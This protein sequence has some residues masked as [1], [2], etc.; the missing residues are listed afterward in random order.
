M[1]RHDYLQLKAHQNSLN[2]AK[3]IIA[4]L[5]AKKPF[6]LVEQIISC[7]VSIPSNIAEGAQMNSDIHF[8]K[9]LYIASGSA[10]ELDSQLRI[11]SCIPVLDEDAKML[12]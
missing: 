8:K 9:Y 2:L 3:Q 6:R 12:G 4:T 10:A 11:L 1:K 5:Y 7:S